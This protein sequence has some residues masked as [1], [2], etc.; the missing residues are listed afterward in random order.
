MSGA[1]ATLTATPDM[2]AGAPAC[3]QNGDNSVDCLVTVTAT[4]SAVGLRSATLTVTLPTAGWEN[5]SGSIA[6]GGTVP[7]SV[8]VADNASTT[9]NGVSTPVAPSTN[10]VLS[11]IVPQGLA[12]DG[13]GNVYTMDANSGSILESVQGAAGVAIAA[14]LP[15]NSSQ[16]AVDQLGDVFAVGSGTASIEELKVSGAPA[17]AGAPATFTSSTISYATVNGGTPAPQGVAVDSAGDIYVADNQGSAENNG[18]YR[19][20]LETNPALQQVTVAT[21]FSNP[22]SLAV[23]GSGDV[24]VADKGAGAVYKLAPNT[25]GSYT[26]STLLSGVTP[27]AVATDAAGDVYVQDQSSATVIEIPLSGA[28]TPVL[29][30]LQA[31]TGVAVDGFGNLYSADAT[32]GN[33]LRVVRDA[34]SYGST[35]SPLTNIAAT[36]TNV[37]NRAATGTAQTQ[38]SDFTISASDCTV[39]SSN[40]IAV[41]L[42]CPVSAALSSSALQNPGTAYTDS[43]SF[44][45]TPSVGSVSFSDVVPAGP[46]ST[47]LV[48]PTN[49]LFASSG[50]EATFIAT[51]TGI[52]SPS[53]SPISVTVN[54]ITLSGTAVVYSSTPTL[55]A[56]GQAS[57][58]LSGLA[59][60]NFSI[61]V[62]YSGVTNT[63]SPSNASASFTVE[64]YVATGD[65]RTV[66]EPTIPAICTVLNADLT[67]V[68]NDIPAS[69][70]STVTN[71]DGAR[72]QAALS[73]CSGTGQAVELSAGSGGN[74]AFLSGPLSMPSNVTLL[75]DPGAVLF[76]SRNVQDYD[77]T[78]GTHTCG[79]VNNNSATASCLPLI[80]IPGGA[81]N[82]GIMGFGKLDGRG[83]DALLNAFPSSF[84]GQSWWGLSSIANNGGTQQN[85][86]FIQMD[87]GSSNITLYKITLRNSPLFH[88]S[89]TGAVS[90]FTAW[91][92]KI[93]TPTSSRNTDGI[94]P[95]NA[96]N[97]TITR[98]WI[99]DGDDNVAVGAAG[100]TPAA[101]I[102]VTNNRFFAGH[103]ESIGSYTQGG[104]SNVLFDSNML[105]GN[106]IAGASSSINNTADSNS[107]GLRIKS[108]FDRGGLVTNIQYSNS[109]FQDHKAEIVFNPNYENTTGS[110]APNL[111]NILM[112][113]LAFL[114][115]G[116]AQFTGTSDNST[117]YPLQLTM[118]NVSFPNPFTAAEFSPAP[119]EAA[120]SYGPGQVSND[121]I[122]DYATFAGANGNTV[123]NN[124][125]ENNLNP[126]VCSFTY[127]A[128]E[129]TGPN[130][131]SQTITEGQ[132]AT[133]VTIL[134]PA[135]GGAAYPT[136]T[137][138]LTDALTSA[139]TS[140]TLPGNTDTLFIPLTGLAPGTHSFTATYSGDS[141]YTLTAGQTAYSTA[142]PYVVTVNAGSLGAT[143]T[144]LS[145]LPSSIEFGNSFTATATVSG[146]NPTGTAEFIV[147]GTVYQSAPVSSGTASATIT[148]AYS[149][150]AYSIYAVYSGDSVND[151]SSSATQSVT[152]TPALTTTALS[153]NTTTTTLGHPV[154]LTATV[155]SSVGAPTGTVTF[156]YTT[157]GSGTPQA[158]TATLAASSNP[159]VSVA[160][161]GIDLLVGRDNVT[162]TYAASGSFAG[163]AS[164]PMAFAVTAGTIIPLPSN[165]IPLP[166]TMT[167][168][169]GGATAGAQAK[170]TASATDARRHRSSLAVR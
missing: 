152:V 124:I 34:G 65:S 110:V 18:I 13:A 120:L 59:P 43:L 142:G 23:D 53:G 116:T 76:F 30:G 51:V 42:A 155:T 69:V 46:T 64:Q 45:A 81:T 162:A 134:T 80:D 88:V 3:T 50:T 14:H 102:S 28:E 84:A 96:Q 117:I 19:L 118:D 26:Q 93:V 83:G 57:I 60:G 15:S 70:D 141:N 106:G 68:N 131:V 148:L 144:T 33:V 87:S 29:T 16:I 114:T 128:P 10:A 66:S 135:V 44:L 85:P 146:S 39:G 99:S 167:T 145:T 97:F 115:V 164:T 147:N 12:V 75:V 169:A 48:G 78:P 133:A 86:R 101:N 11:G 74:N 37:G 95:G 73:S 139:T 21:G 58:A 17:S 112:Q 158:T 62:S 32:K 72:I 170:P 9:A 55:N 105:S 150:S 38:A 71:P 151:G 126:P 5:A 108:G 137:V 107:T 36:L 90:N 111:E 61:A 8:M 82:V 67:M 47:T 109:C 27:V 24:F 49:P 161:A 156:T 149:T 123:T 100:S 89:T 157:T 136:G 121:F 104:V 138:T 56:S 94:D 127:I 129:L 160:T 40:S 92:I 22:V 79:T 7:G 6:L 31:P 35:S 41:G 132:N 168:V 91:D 153:A 4:P 103:G 98:S 143:T 166:Y 125:T 140:V 20:T 113:N 1:T 130:G 77:S 52:S 165:P 119:T 163:S 2:S 154:V 25:N 159:N 63:Y 122:S 54:S